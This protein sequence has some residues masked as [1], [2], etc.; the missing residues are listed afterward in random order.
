MEWPNEFYIKTLDGVKLTVDYNPLE[1][2]IKLE[3]ILA[4]LLLNIKLYLVEKIWTTK[5][6]LQNTE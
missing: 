5:K 6:L 2:K 4:F 1:S 3:S